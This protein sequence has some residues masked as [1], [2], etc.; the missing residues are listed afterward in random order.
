M[1]SFKE[2]AKSAGWSNEKTFAQFFDRPIREYFLN[3]FVTMKIAGFYM[4]MYVYGVIYT[5]SI[6][7]MLI[8]QQTVLIRLRKILDS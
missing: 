1:L 2:I 6:C 5:G 3:H 8:M 7:M 4:Y